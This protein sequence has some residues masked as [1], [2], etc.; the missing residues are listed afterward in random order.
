MHPSVRVRFAPSPTGL[1]HL[2]SVRTAL[3]NYIFAQ[4]N[5]GRFILRIEDTDA[6]RNF[7]PGAQLILKDLG[8][9]GLTFD[10]GPGK[11]STFGPFFQSERSPIY[12]QYLQQLINQQRVYR[13]F[14]TP[15]DL[16]KKRLRQITLKKP[17]R[18]DRAC[19]NLSQQEHARLLDIQTPFIWRFRLDNDQT[20]HINDIVRG[21]IEFH[22]SNFS[23]FPLTRADGSFTFLFSN[24]IDDITMKITHI[25]RGEDHISNTPCQAALYQACNASLPI[26]W[27]MPVICNSDGKKLSKRDFG[28]SLQDLQQAGYLPEA[29]NNYLGIIG[30]SCEKEIMTLHEL[31]QTIDFKQQSMSA[32]KYDVDKLNWVNHEW[33]KKYN[34]EALL[35]VGLPFLMKFYPQAANLPQ[36]ELNTLFSL[37]HP[38][39]KTL[40]DIPTI[41]SWYF[42]PPTITQEHIEK[43]TSLPTAQSIISLLVQALNTSDTPQKVL[44]ACKAA[45]KEKGISA[46]D[47]WKVARF[48]LTGNPE[49]MSVHDI[50]TA[51]G[52]EKTKERLEKVSSV[53]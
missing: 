11:P 29:I 34:L 50:I 33:L 51:L 13:C 8:W 2:G 18:Y 30:S 42:Q 32:I 48:A 36:Q 15:E 14:C 43:I 21:S 12:K 28:F 52:I 39:I 25:F 26:F 31:V 44:D 1:L 49:G 53:F 38:E 20:I 27:H 3:F 19:L 6:E 47:F 22:M 45:I 46:K 40:G 10:E 7:D 9:L 5:K 16:E 17:P 4:K 37:V 24:A 35:S 41:L 23:D